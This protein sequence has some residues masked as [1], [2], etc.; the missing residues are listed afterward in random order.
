MA[1]V[2]AS[3]LDKFANVWDTKELSKTTVL[4]AMP[5][6]KQAQVTQR[7]QRASDYSTNQTEFTR[8]GLQVFRQ[9]PTSD[10]LDVA[11]MVITTSPACLWR[12]G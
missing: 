4:H 11:I 12:F 2:Y 10:D 5:L 9:V 3:H 1:T 6:L 8:P 7:G